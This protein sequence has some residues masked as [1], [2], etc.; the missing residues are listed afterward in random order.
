MLNK[1]QQKVKAMGRGLAKLGREFVRDE[2][3][4]FVGTFG[5]MAIVSVVLVIAHGLITGWLPGF[6]ESIFDR[7]ESLL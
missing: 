3:G 1:V 2:R 6:I 5:W 7:M 4:E